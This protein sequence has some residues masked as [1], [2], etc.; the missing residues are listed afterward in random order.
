[1]AFLRRR[2]TRAPTTPVAS[3]TRL[4]GSGTGELVDDASE[5]LSTIEKDG[6]IAAVKLVTG[7]EEMTPINCKGGIGAELTTT[8]PLESTRVTCPGRPL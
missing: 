6:R 7:T 8:S 3:R 4:A 1:M 5:K 2:R